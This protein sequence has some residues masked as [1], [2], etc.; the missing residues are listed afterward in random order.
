ME[1]S[2]SQVLQEARA[3]IAQPAGWT[4]FQSFRS[5]PEGGI[6]Y[7]A[8]GALCLPP[9]EPVFHTPAQR[10]AVAALAGAL[11]P[12]Y[13]CIATYNDEVG[14]TQADILALYDR[15]LTLVTK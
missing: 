4:K 7:C 12:G 10:A 2:T 8:W 5:N 3:R 1:K 9:L 13:I 14:T 15:A 11:P 6:R